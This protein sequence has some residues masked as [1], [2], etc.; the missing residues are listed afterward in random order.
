MNLSQLPISH[1]VFVE[2][3]SCVPTVAGKIYSG[4]V[5]EQQEND[6]GG[7]VRVETLAAKH[8]SAWWKSL[9]F[10]WED[11]RSPVDKWIVLRVPETEEEAAALRA[12]VEQGKRPETKEITRPAWLPYAD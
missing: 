6:Y 11:G 2:V 10:R 3:E 7:S 8:V 9:S 4:T 5:L 1:P 12:R